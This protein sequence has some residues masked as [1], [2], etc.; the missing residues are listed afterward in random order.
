M[1]YAVQNKV[2]LPNLFGFNQTLTVG[3]GDHPYS[4]GRLF[5]LR[6]EPQKVMDHNMMIDESDILMVYTFMAVGLGRDHFNEDDYTGAIVNEAVAQAV[7]HSSLPF[8]MKLDEGVDYLGDAG[9]KMPPMHIDEVTN[10]NA[11][12]VL[13]N[14]V[15][16]G[17]PM[18]NH[19]IDITY[20]AQWW[21]SLNTTERD[22]VWDKLKRKQVP[23]LL[24]DFG[25]V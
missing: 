18:S 4:L 3:K 17:S 20:T 12:M 5:F 21:L 2:C 14:A 11:D 1:K 19:M 22:D 24:R 6:D 8:C 7:F 13:R 16:A 25:R 15:S 9:S 23:R 10:I